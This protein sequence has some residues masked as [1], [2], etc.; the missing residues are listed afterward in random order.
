MGAARTALYARRAC[1]IFE[2][3]IEH[4]YRGGHGLVDSR[5]S[6]MN[7][8]AALKRLAIKRRNSRW[9]PYKCIGDYHG[10][11]YECNLVSPYTKTA[12]NVDSE[13]FVLLQD[14][15]SDTFLRR[16]FDLERLYWDTPRAYL[17]I[18]TCPVS[19]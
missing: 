12:G 14:W 3:G 19:S 6:A 1:E 11:K 15:S 9:E 4:E 8:R 18:A 10:G 13:I 17:R 5:V 7:K 16:A 2:A